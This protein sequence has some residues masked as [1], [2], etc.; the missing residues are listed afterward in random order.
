[1]ISHVNAEDGGAIFS[2]TYAQYNHA[3]IPSCHIPNFIA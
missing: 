2:T 1:M 3:S